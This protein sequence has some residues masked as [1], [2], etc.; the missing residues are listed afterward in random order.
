M[1]DF[2][3]IPGLTYLGREAHNGVSTAKFSVLS[4]RYELGF[5]TAKD[6]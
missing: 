6:R 5:K 3:D 2:K 1:A 4:G